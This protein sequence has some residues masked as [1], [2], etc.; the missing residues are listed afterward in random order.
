M[1]LVSLLF[2]CLTA[3]C[4]E[5]ASDIAIA[6]GSST[7]K[8]NPGT[9]YRAGAGTVTDDMGALT[10]TSS[11]GG[12]TLTVTVEALTM[13]M[14]VKLGE[15]HLA[16]DYNYGAAAWSSA[17][18]SVTFES[19]APYRVTFNDVEMVAATSEAEGGFVLS[20]TALFR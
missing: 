15:R 3:G 18:G 9:G 19:V 13:P 10:L 6:F 4:V 20:G 2:L 8:P 11:A 12:A 14:T 17:G 16:V 7:A 5:A 1:R